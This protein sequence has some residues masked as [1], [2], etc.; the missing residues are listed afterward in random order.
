MLRCALQDK[1]KTTKEVLRKIDRMGG[2]AVA[3]HMHQQQ[4]MHQNNHHHYQQQQHMHQQQY[5]G[6]GEPMNGH[7]YHT[8]TSHAVG[9][10]ARGG[11]GA[12]AG[13]TP[14]AHTAA[15]APTGSGPN[16][17]LAAGA[18][19]PPQ[20]QYVDVGVA[21]GAGAVATQGKKKSGFINLLFK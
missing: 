1:L 10:Q 19:G 13:L 4:H 12:G 2:T 8:T 21:G 9:P 18:A 6:G 11:P 16:G 20:A 15:M 14:S 3:R 7:Q 17:P 5:S